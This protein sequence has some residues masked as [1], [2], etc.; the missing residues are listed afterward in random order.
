M[1]Q[2][3]LFIIAYTGV[4]TRGFGGQTPS[5]D[6]WKKLKTTLLDRLAF[7]HTEIVFFCAVSNCLYNLE[8]LSL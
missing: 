7:F 1:R 4:R 8:K 5:I 3:K 6:D 2:I